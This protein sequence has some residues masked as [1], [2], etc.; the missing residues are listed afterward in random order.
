M[1]TEDYNMATEDCNMATEGDFEEVTI[2][3]NIL[4]ELADY[5]ISFNNTTHPLLQ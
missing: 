5:G 3:I 2:G 4:Q 1:A